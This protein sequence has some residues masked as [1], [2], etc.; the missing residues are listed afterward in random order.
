VKILI[1]SNAPWCATG[2]GK[3]TRLLMEQLTLHGHDV[4]VSAFSGLQSAEIRW[5]GHTILPGGQMSFGVD[6]LVGHIEH[7]QPDVTLTLMD[8]YM[9]EHIAP[10]LRS[11]MLAAWMPVDCSP[12]SH[13]DRTTLHASAAIPIAMSKFGL[14][15]IGADMPVGYAP[16]SVDTATFTPM[17]D[18]TAFRQELG[19]DEAF[20]IGVNAA[21]RDTTRKAF[22]EQFA[23]F[24]QFRARHPDSV[25][26][27]HSTPRNTAGLDLAQLAYD[28]DVLKH[29]QFSDQYQ[30]DAGLVTDEMM[31]R[32]YGACDVLSLCSYAEGFGV[33]LI[34]AQACGTPVITSNGSAMTELVGPGWLVETE[35]FW[36][37]L[38][39]AW[40]RRPRIDSIVRAYANAYKWVDGNRRERARQFALAYDTST[41]FEEHWMPILKEW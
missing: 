14:H 32:W 13:G 3:Q 21:N 2:Y 36:N 4:G 39:R 20:V 26:L 8:T 10:A 35:P 18:R 11:Y 5:K 7:Y 24:A 1:H 16:H 6:V 38:H 27:V 40:W 37:P 41:V 12:L 25:M 17:D 15:T 22:S 9:L 31:R 33:P 29:V 34:E 23:A 30:Q 19:I 28:H